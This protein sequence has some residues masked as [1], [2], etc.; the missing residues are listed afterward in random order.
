MS[1]TVTVHD[2]MTDP[3]LLG[4]QF[5]GKSWNTWRVLLAGFYGL[6]MNE[7]ELALF[8]RITALP[9]AVQVPLL[10]LW[11]AIGRR[12]GKSQIAALLAIFEGCFNDLIRNH[13]GFYIDIGFLNFFRYS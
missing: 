13:S 4:D 5:G 11:L 2:L 3:D 6:P 7:V 9:E 12:G 8:Q 1:G 10:E